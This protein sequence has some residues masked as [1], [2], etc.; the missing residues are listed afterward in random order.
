[1]KQS[2]DL[3]G[4]RVGLFT[5]DPGRTTGVTISTITLEGTVKE[6]FERDPPFYTQINCWDPDVPE[7]LCE[8]KGAAVLA[9]MFAEEHLTRWQSLP[10]SNI[11]F[12]S[13]DFVI[14]RNPRS[15]AREGLSPVR[16]FSLVQGI[17]IG[18][19]VQFLAQ[20]NGAAMQITHDRLRQYGLWNRGDSNLP[21]AVDAKRHA[22]AWV[23]RVLQRGF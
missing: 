11:F 14:D 17:L 7:F 5:M 18:D 10:S 22:V 8:R 23:R 12:L 15:W 4:E 13:E 16:V 20:S 19:D 3:R 6:I 2:R 1:M 9:E 21:H